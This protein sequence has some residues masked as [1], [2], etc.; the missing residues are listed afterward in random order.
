[1]KLPFK[2]TQLIDSFSFLDLDLGRLVPLDCIGWGGYINKLRINAVVPVALVILA[3]FAAL[4]RVRT[5][6]HLRGR[7]LLRA[8][9]LTAT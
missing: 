4:V 3:G 8:S 5:I 1:M 7:K 6:T 9:G 2:V